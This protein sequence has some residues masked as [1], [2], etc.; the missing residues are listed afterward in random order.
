MAATMYNDR[1]RSWQRLPE[2]RAYRSLLGRR[3]WR[4]SHPA[5]T[6]LA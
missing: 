1:N 2:L 6:G 3:P 5:T 4:C